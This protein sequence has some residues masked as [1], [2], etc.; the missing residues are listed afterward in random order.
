MPARFDDPALVE[1]ENYVGRTHR[2]E[3]VRDDDRGADALP[4][5]NCG[6]KVALGLDI[7]RG[8]GLIQ[9]QDRRVPKE[10]AGDRYA[11]PL[12]AGE[13]RAAF[14]QLRCDN[15]SGSLRMKPSA[16]A[17]S[18]AAGDPSPVGA[19]AAKSDVLLGRQRKKEG[20]LQHQA[21][22]AAKVVEAPFA[23]VDAVKRDAPFVGIEQ[24][25]RERDQRGFPRAGG[26]D[27][28]DGLAGL[29][30]HVDV[31]KGGPALAVA[32]GHVLEADRA[33]RPFRSS[34]RRRARGGSS[35]TSR[36]DRIAKARRPFAAEWA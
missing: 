33:L 20:V 18:A 9:D 27:D 14:A 23:Q 24:P 11:L 16:P 29:D 2:R 17:A 34:R 3:P 22:L 31:A 21:E 19:R 6:E 7:Q 12:A 30:L 8:R 28:G 25:Q 15:R 32:E 5:V 35:T 36:S 10:S 13:R 1:H 4:R 26:T